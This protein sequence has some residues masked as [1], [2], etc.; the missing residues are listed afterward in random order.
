[1]S[2]RIIG[3]GTMEFRLD[4][5]DGYERLSDEE[6]A[7]LI[8]TSDE[9]CCFMDKE[10]G[11]SV[12]VTSKDTGRE[13]DMN[14]DAVMHIYSDMCRRSVPGFSNPSMGKKVIGGKQF[15]ALQ[16]C[17]TTADRDIFDLLF[18]TMDKTTQIVITMQCTLKDF[19]KAKPEFMKMIDTAKITA[20]KQ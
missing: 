20:G 15:G 17:S 14:I 19:M 12:T 16:F 7:K 1:M 5:P 9:C 6:T 18:V 2:E 10:R 13:S 4:I 8:R 3:A 11:Y